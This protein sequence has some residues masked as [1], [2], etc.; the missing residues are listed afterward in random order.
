MLF[1]MF[2]KLE[3]MF[4]EIFPLGLFEQTKHTILKI[5]ISNHE[6]YTFGIL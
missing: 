2:E 6:F 1:G 5:T 4:F 3:K